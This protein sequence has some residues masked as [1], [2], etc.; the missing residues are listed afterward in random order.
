M[1]YK[2]R[3]SPITQRRAAPVVGKGEHGRPVLLCP[4]CTPGHPIMP[5]TRYPCGTILE[6]TAV[7]SVLRAK[8]DKHV[9]CIKCGKGGGQMRSYGDAYVHINDCLPGTEVL[10]EVPHSKLAE[11]VYTSPKW[12][13]KLF[14]RMG[15][16]Q[17]IKEINLDGTQTG[18]ILGYTF[19]KG[20]NEL[21]Q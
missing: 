1:K 5:G 18:K 6:V 20:K 21:S 10:S 4:F 15:V 14:S 2:P 7:Q 12:V 8:F 3:K 9:R 13:G 17:P 16:P 19:L 11:F